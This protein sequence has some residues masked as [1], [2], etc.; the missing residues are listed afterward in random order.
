MIFETVYLNDYSLFSFY[1]PHKYKV[2]L[3]CSA[4]RLARFIIRFQGPHP[5]HVI[6]K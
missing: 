3:H 5:I 1:L 4:Y 6:K 2:Y